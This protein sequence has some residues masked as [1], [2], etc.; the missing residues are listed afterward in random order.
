MSLTPEQENALTQAVDDRMANLR[1]LA[2]LRA[3]SRRRQRE[4]HTARR[5]AGLKLRHAAKLAR[6]EGSAE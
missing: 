2:A 3:E 4:Q 1:Q 5:T 6:T